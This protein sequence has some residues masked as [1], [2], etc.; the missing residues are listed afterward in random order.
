M[1]EPSFQLW[2]AVRY[3]HVA[4]V[5][6]LAGGA[7]L[8]AA[9]CLGRTA[10]GARLALIA[11]PIYEWTFWL[12]TG[13]VAVTGVSNLGL[14]GEGLMSPATSWGK[15]LT[16][17]LTAVLALLTISLLR[18]DVVIR[19]GGAARRATSDRAR[20]IAG[21]LYAATVG[22]LLVAMWIG[23]GLAHGRY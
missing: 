15:A 18:S 19:C 14:K 11:A 5:A 1:L 12:L 9:W 7:T 10:D 17:K 16:T 2:F 6:V 4:S 13:F 21:C 20:V 23:L 8:L 22:I 3:V